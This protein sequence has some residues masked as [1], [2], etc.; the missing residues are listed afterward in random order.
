VGNV[1]TFYEK[2]KEVEYLFTEQDIYGFKYV[3]TVRNIIV[4]DVLENKLRDRRKFEGI[5]KQLKRAIQ[6][7]AIR[8]SEIRKPVNV[9]DAQK[10]PCFIATAVYGS[11]EQE[12]VRKL[13]HFR[14]TQLLTTASGRF[15]VKIYYFC[16]PPIA[17][18]LRKHQTFA[19]PVR[20]LLDKI[21][22]RID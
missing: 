4:H 5:V 10:G 14:D 21:V 12:N 1:T 9:F 11:Y 22:A 6:D 16:S 19:M 7:A 17:D 8:R 20:K 2:Q 18:F 13:R 15:F 3:S